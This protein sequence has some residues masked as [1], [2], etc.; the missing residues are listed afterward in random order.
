MTDK[1]TKGPW[2][3]DQY[4]HIVDS[5]GREIHFRGVCIMASGERERIDQAERNSDLA[6]CAPSLIAALRRY[7]DMDTRNKLTDNHLYRTA[8]SVIESAT[9]EK[10]ENEFRFD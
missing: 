9:G 8:V 2:S 5:L 4:G 7:V 3:R 1:F 10:Y 6:A